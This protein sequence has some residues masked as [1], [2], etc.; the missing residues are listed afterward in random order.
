M[1]PCD[2]QTY[3]HMNFRQVLEKFGPGSVDMAPQL[4]L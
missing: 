2:L 4:Q 3:P 1:V